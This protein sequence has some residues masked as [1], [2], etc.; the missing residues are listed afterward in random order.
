MLVI[1]VTVIAFAAA[2]AVAV[3]P[4]IPAQF[5]MLRRVPS[6]HTYLGPEPAQIQWLETALVLLLLGYI[7]F[8]RPFAWIH[9]PGTPLF[10]GESVIAFGVWVVLS[11]KTGAMSL[12]RGSSSLSSLRNFMLWGGVLL[13]IGILPYSLDAIRDSAIWYYGIIAIFVSILLVSDPSRVGKWMLGF[14]RFVPIMLLWFP[15]ATVLA[16]VAPD[17]I[18]VP[19]SEIPIFFHRVGNMA[20]LSSIAVGFLW[21]ADAD[22]RIFTPRQRAWLTMIAT[23][24]IV[25]TGLQNRGGMVAS[26]ALFAALLFLLSKRRVEMVMMMMGVLVLFAIVGIVFDVKIQLFSDREI[27]MEQ[28]SQNITSIFNQDE[29]GYRQTQ[30]TAWRIRIWEQVLDDV[31]TESPVMGFGMGPDL[32]ER[33]G[34]TTDEDTPLRNPHNSHVGVLAR[35]GWVGVILWVILWITWVAELQTLRRRLRY[36]N[37]PKESS[38]VSWI[39]ISPIPILVNAIFDPTLEGAQVAMQLWA[40]FG[41]GAA[42]VILAQQNRFPSLASIGSDRSTRSPVRIH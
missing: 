2:I 5:N 6:A 1:V 37:R 18:F 20:V 29:G 32:G 7:F 14:G 25:L 17:N 16:A 12:I 33:Y 39:M 27:S 10:I 8:D 31:S 23:L 9:I 30:T 26:V 11:S 21:M 36:R 35:M 19:D 41:V 24:V 28:F 4:S 13:A 38:F 3:R 34:I 40:F 15:I 22:S 42:L